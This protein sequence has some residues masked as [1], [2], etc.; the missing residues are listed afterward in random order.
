MDPSCP[1]SVVEASGGGVIVWGIFSGHALEPWA[2][3]DHFLN[4][5]SYLSIVAD[6]VH[7][8]T[9]Q[10]GHLLMAT[11]S[12]ILARST[13]KLKHSQIGFLNMTMSSLYTNGLHSHHDDHDMMLS[14]HKE[15]K[16]YWRQKGV[17]PCISNGYLMKWL[18][19]I[20]RCY[21]HWMTIRAMC[22]SKNTT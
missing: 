21:V 6:H 17:Q 12:R 18:V 11:P 22:E 16:Q 19:S 1:V 5:T 2:P 8:C 10:H 15:F 7:P 14:C 20:A 4:S 9:S 3:I 13:A